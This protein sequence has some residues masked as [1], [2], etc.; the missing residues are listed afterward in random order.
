[1]DYAVSYLFRTNQLEN[2]DSVSPLA[3]QVI[4]T[5]AS[6]SDT[7]TKSLMIEFK[8]LTWKTVE[9]MSGKGLVSDTKNL[10]MS[11]IE[12]LL[13]LVS[14]ATDPDLARLQFWIAVCNFHLK[15]YRTS[16]EQLKTLL[17]IYEKNEANE[18]GELDLE[19][20]EK[21]LVKVLWVLNKIEEALKIAKRSYERLPVSRSGGRAHHALSI[22]MLQYIAKL[23]FHLGKV[24]EAETTLDR[25]KAALLI[26]LNQSAR[27]EPYYIRLAYDVAELYIKRV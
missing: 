20:V 11:F 7:E 24:A 6:S 3:K 15:D 27:L 12:I 25:V 8:A 22:I 9:V 19:N 2:E 23:L 18:F 13:P 10:G 26:N 14:S 4:S 1:L 21:Y 16:E 17:P 5:F